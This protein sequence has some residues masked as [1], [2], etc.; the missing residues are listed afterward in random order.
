MFTVEYQTPFPLWTRPVVLRNRWT[1][2]IGIMESTGHRIPSRTTGWESRWVP[3]GSG[4]TFLFFFFY[5]IPRNNDVMV[6]REIRKKCSRM[7][8]YVY[9]RIVEKQEYHTL[10]ELLTLSQASSLL[11]TV[12]AFMNR[13]TS[14]SNKT[15]IIKLRRKLWMSVVCRR[16]LLSSYRSYLSQLWYL[17]N[18][19]LVFNIGI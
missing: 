13:R 10:S 14:A 3:P 1:G 6:V 19:S 9:G 18:L 7:W 16:Y 8:I 12:W 2:L 4:H 15:S 11:S 17:K 5:S